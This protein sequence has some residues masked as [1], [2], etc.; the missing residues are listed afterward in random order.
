VPKTTL[1]QNTTNRV[2]K[3]EEKQNLILKFQ[4]LLPRIFIYLTLLRSDLNCCVTGRVLNVDE[5]ILTLIL[6]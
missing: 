2:K 6:L 5:F 4:I 3:E 1:Y